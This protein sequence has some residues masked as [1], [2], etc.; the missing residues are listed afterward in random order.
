MSESTVTT[1][2]KETL[3]KVCEQR[4]RAFAAL[5]NMRYRFWAAHYNDAFAAQ[6]RREKVEKDG[7][8][9][10]YRCSAGKSLHSNFHGCDLFEKEGVCKAGDCPMGFHHYNCY[11]AAEEA[12]KVLS[13]RPAEFAH[14]DLSRIPDFDPSARY[15][16]SARWYAR[17]CLMF[18]NEFHIGEQYSNDRS[19]A[20]GKALVSLVGIG[21][22]SLGV[23][24]PVDFVTEVINHNT[25]KCFA[26]DDPHFLEYKE[27][28]KGF[29]EKYGANIRSMD[30][31]KVFDREARLANND[32]IALAFLVEATLTFLISFQIGHTYPGADLAVY[33]GTVEALRY[34]CVSVL[35]IGRNR[36]D[37]I[38]NMNNMELDKDFSA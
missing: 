30:G 7:T 37:L 20:F 28:M 17:M 29:N 21:F 33:A 10:E 6:D 27:T 38:E 26:D 23:K 16:V 32:D 31:Q 13:E 12:S 25:D 22:S 9:K 8:K 5:E 14:F 3:R 18:F 15:S 4:D 1:D 24:F 36:F 34:D 2:N 35:G 19:D 11:A